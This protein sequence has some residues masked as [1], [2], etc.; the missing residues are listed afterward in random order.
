MSFRDLNLARRPFANTRPV[1]RVS[2]LL[3]TLAILLACINGW[4]YGR[5]L[6]GMEHVEERLEATDQRILAEEDRLAE[7]EEVLRGMDLRRQNAEAR[8]LNARIAERSF[9][10]SRLFDHLA[11]VLP[12]EVRLHTLS[13]RRFEPEPIGPGAEAERTE[14]PEATRE[15]R[16]TLTLRGNAR[17]DES[18]LAFLDNL[19]D[20]SRFRD[21]ELSS[22]TRQDD[23]SLRFRLS[24]TYIPGGVEERERDAVVPLAE[25]GAGAGAEPTAAPTGRRASATPEGRG[26]LASEPSRDRGPAAEPGSVARRRS[27]I[28]SES[29]VTPRP[30]ER[31]GDVVPAPPRPSASRP[32]GED[33]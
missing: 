5:S 12:R 30:S 1:V 4:L 27:E 24:V 28:R 14:R 29:S 31:G 6:S 23:N 2:I 8:Y 15:D 18:L 33:R 3:W 26:E 17:G 11:E 22:E 25:A 16:A 19:F 10:W 9:P 32:P 13:P 21:P 20:S 7:A